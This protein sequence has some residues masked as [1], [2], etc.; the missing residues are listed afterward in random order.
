[1]ESGK[2]RHVMVCFFVSRS[3]HIRVAL[4]LHGVTDRVRAAFQNYAA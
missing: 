4:A 1:M 3:A 2:S